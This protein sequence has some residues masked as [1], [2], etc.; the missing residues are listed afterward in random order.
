MRY[1]ATFLSLL[2][3]T[4]TSVF[5]YANLTPAQVNNRI[6]QGDT[7]L[8][9]DV[10]EVREYQIGHIAEPP[11]QLPLTPA[12][13]PLNSQVLAK[14]Y[15]RL[16]RDIDIIVYCQGGGR[17]AS[18]S[19]FLESKGFTRIYNMTG[20]FSSWT[21]AGRNGGYGDH[22]GQWVR[23]S[24]TLPVVIHCDI[25]TDTST[26][27]FAP[28]AVPESENSI[29]VELHRSVDHSPIP[30]DVPVSEYNGLYRLTVLDEFGMSFF[31]SDSL[32]VTEPVGITLYPAHDSNDDL[33]VNVHQMYGYIPGTGWSELE[34]TVD[35]SGFLHQTV[36]IR[37]WYSV[38]AS[39][40]TGM[41][42][43]VETVKD[44]INI[45][46][47]PFNS[48]IHIDAPRDA[49]ISVYDVRGRLIT[50]LESGTWIPPY[51]L[52]SGLYIIFIQHSDR[53]WTKRVSYIK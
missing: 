24:E 39:S 9:L 30:P 6:V 50:G 34:H 45:F 46:P 33:S 1:Y 2:V 18:A 7:L 41:E 16:P 4:T 27:T 40:S 17:S 37:K 35:A 32:K 49:I 38:T 19:S 36:M 53:V 11:G 15:H 13:M 12:N 3:F 10:R 43:I 47:N 22:S 28:A 51:H 8:L 44:D 31:R 52:G 29:Y 20:G 26:I 25:G 21:F 14:E 5:G 23:K 48:G 42:R